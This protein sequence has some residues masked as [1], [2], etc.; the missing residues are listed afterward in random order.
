MVRD[1]KLV[2]VH[3][4]GEVL[5]KDIT[6]AIVNWYEQKGR[7][8]SWN[9]YSYSA[10]W[11]IAFIILKERIRENLQDRVVYTDSYRPDELQLII[12][13]VKGANNL[14]EGDLEQQDV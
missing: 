1:E 11:A 8:I 6:K 10:L 5:T 13:K 9:S 7:L 12:S 3:P 2:N 14:Y 4:K